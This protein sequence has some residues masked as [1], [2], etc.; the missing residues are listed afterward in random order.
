MMRNKMGGIP[1][2]VGQNFILKNTLFMLLETR[3]L[4]EKKPLIEILKCIKDIP[5]SV[6]YVKHQLK[7]A[8]IYY[9]ILIIKKRSIL[10]YIVMKIGFQTTENI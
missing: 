6:I 7:F 2:L 4:F 1:I 3:R 8:Q 10:L 5:L 9:D